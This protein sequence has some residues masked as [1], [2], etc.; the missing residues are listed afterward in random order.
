MHGVGKW[1]HLTIVA[2]VSNPGGFVGNLSLKGTSLPFSSIS[3]AIG[4]A[5][6]VVSQITESEQ[7]PRNPSI[8]EP[9]NAYGY[10]FGQAV[11]EKYLD[12]TSTMFVKT[13]ITTNMKC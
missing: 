12:T 13:K 5:G 3:G 2:I 6:I 10:S 1:G 8:S 11:K 7:K 4:V 9:S